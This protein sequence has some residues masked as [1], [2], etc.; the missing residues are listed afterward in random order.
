ME[1][2]DEND[3]NLHVAVFSALIW[4]HHLTNDAV[5]IQW[6]ENLQRAFNFCNNSSN[7]YEK[8]FND[9]FV[10][11]YALGFSVVFKLFT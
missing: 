7:D 2:R 8:I 4:R 10:F 11:A 9:N 5:S 3:E 1:K 6:N